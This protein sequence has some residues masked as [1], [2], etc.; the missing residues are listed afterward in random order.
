MKHKPSIIDLGL[1]AAMMGVA[2]YLAYSV[3]IFVDEPGTS[4]HH[5]RIETDE[6]LLLGA[7]LMLGLLIFSIRRF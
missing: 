4:D 2:T 3:N 1:L 5:L 7:L 6:L